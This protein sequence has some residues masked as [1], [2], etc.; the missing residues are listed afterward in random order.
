M[1]RVEEF[2]E[3]ELQP[4]GP[5]AGTMQHGENLHVLAAETVSDN[6]WGTR[7]DEFSCPVHATLAAH[8]RMLFQ[9]LHR[10]KDPFDH[11]VGRCRSV[12]GEK[13]V[14]RLQ[15]AAGERRPA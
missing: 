1:W 11:L 5:S 8:F 14:R 13:F 12:L 6:K 15:V 3:R 7:D 2:L 9:Q 10:R 4:V